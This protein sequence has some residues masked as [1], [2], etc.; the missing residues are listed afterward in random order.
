MP[1]KSRI[2]S[3]WY[4]IKGSIPTTNK[5]GKC[6]WSRY[7]SYPLLPS[8]LSIRLRCASPQTAGIPIRSPFTIS[9]C[10]KRIIMVGLIKSAPNYPTPL[11][12]ETMWCQ[13][14]DLA[15]SN[16][17]RSLCVSILRLVYLY[18]FKRMLI[19]ESRGEYGWGGEWG[20]ACPSKFCCNIMPLA[21]RIGV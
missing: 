3:S 8:L 14:N 5:W 15:Y 6:V 21:V 17:T 9:S 11:E 16:F 18:L 19:V 13:Y 12:R 2:F 1:K 20:E 10:S 4:C 7:G